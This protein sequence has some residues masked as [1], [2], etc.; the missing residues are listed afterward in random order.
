M[1][2]A[3]RLA[4]MGSAVEHGEASAEAFRSLAA[5]VR[6]ALTAWAAG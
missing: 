1:V 4:E 2:G 5:Q 6:A 3:P